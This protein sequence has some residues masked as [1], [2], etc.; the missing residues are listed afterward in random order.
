MNIKAIIYVLG[1]VF[2]CE[3]VLMLLPF[4]VSLI[5]RESQG[6]AFLAVSAL[7]LILGMLLISKKPKNM[8]IYAKEGFVTVA[9]SW[10]VFRFFWLSAF[11]I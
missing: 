1:W 10:I 5:Y 7:C 11:Y 6:M 4:I 3:G 9:F 2:N 8:T